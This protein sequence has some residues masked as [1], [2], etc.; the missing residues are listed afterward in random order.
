VRLQEAPQWR[1]SALV[2]QDAHLRRRKRAPC[3][4]FQHSASLLDAYTGEPLD[5]LA[6]LRAIFEVLEQC[7][8]RDARAHEYPC[9]TYTL[10]ISLDG[11]A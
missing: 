11:R 8:Y 1:G 4:M 5:E 10:G 2:E 3:G 6:D 7:G 9:A